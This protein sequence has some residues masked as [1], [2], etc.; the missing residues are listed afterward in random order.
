MLQCVHVVG[1]YLEWKIKKSLLDD[2]IP[3]RH[4]REPCHPHLLSLTEEVTVTV[5]V[6]YPQSSVNERC[7]FALEAADGDLC[8]TDIL[9]LGKRWVGRD[10]GESN[11][12]ALT[13]SV[14]I[15]DLERCERPKTAFLEIYRCGG[16]LV[17]AS[18]GRFGIKWATQVLSGFQGPPTICQLFLASA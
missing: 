16:A 18:L 7:S 13:L 8:I 14:T 10:G 2:L 9:Y 11:S 5:I 3:Q 12:A 6:T 4:H 15:N 17:Q 1:L